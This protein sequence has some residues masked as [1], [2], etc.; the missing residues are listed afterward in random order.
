MG[1]VFF[2]IVA[3]VSWVGFI[4]I[5]VAVGINGGDLQGVSGDNFQLR[6]ALGALDGIALFYLIYVDIQRVIAFRANNSHGAN[7]S[8][9]GE[10][11]GYIISREMQGFR[12]RA[13]S[14]YNF[15]GKSHARTV[16]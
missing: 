8:A 3:G 12:I 4:L 15:R 13:P 2:L 9:A 6:A 14:F 7:L 10:S 5:I 11:G 1:L 16:P